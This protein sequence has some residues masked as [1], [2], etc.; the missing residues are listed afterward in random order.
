M[1]E[2]ITQNVDII[3]EKGSDMYNRILAE[4]ER[5]GRDFSE[6]LRTAVGWGVYGHMNSNLDLMGRIMPPKEGSA[7]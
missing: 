1:K 4:A 3:I 5:S 2:F 6:V 7:E